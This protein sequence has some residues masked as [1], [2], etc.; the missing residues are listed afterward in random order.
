MPAAEPGRRWY[1]A[2]IVGLFVV[3][4]AGIALIGGPGP[5][6][7]NDAAAAAQTRYAATPF[8]GKS[9]FADLRK[10]CE[11]GPRPSGSTAMLQQQQLLID[12]FTALGAKASKQSF[13]IR[14]PVDGTPVDMSNLLIEWSPETNTERLLL[15]AHYDTRPYPDRDPVR[16]Q[17]RFIGA[18]DGGSGVAVLMELGRHM[19]TLPTKRGVDFV[20]FDGEELVYDERHEYFHGSKYFAQWYRATPPTYRYRAGVLLDMVAD[21]QLFIRK[22]PNSLRYARFVVDDVWGAAFRLGVREFS[23]QV[24]QEVRDDHLPLNEIARIPTIDVIDFDYPHWHTEADV[25]E[26]CSA[27]SLEKVGKVMY[28]WLR[29]AITR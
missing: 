11:L 15:C 13:R 12:H 9:A 10:V 21:A 22:E 18:N 26:S 2:A 24:G 1:P 28:E 8:D 19:S 7:V 23:T 27:E 29:I 3:G 5:T 6:D 4:L 14:H 17:G 20:F 25:P 16:R